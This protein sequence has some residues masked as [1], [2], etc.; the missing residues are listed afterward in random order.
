[1]EG[2]EG[3]DAVLREVEIDPSD[4]LA[5]LYREV[6]DGLKLSATPGSVHTFK[7]LIMPGIVRAG[8]VTERVRGGYEAADVHIFT[9]LRVLE[10]L[11]QSGPVAPG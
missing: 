2:F 1:M 7:G 11:E 5:A 3:F 9:D 10:E 4:F 8:L 6:A